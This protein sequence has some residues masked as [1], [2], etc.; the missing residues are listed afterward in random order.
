MPLEMEYADDV[1]F[2]DEEKDT[3]DRLLPVAAQNLK[4]SNLFMNE[5]KTEF[6]HV[7]LSDTQEKE[8]N[9]KPLQGKE[10]WRKSKILGSLLCSSS[11][12]E[13]CCVMGN[14]AF[15][16]FWKIWICGSKIP[17][18]KKLQLYNATCVSIMLYNCN[19][20]AAPK[21]AMDK[22]D[23]CHRKHLRTITGH[24]W[25]DS[26]ISNEALYKMCKTTPLSTKVHQLRWT[27]FGHV[28]RMPEDTPA[29]KALEFAVVGS[30]KYKAH[31]G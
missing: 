4:D 30:N 19:S 16:S 24:K 10:D 20:W 7:Y 27:M 15:Q 5:A 8:E 28:L 6:T 29:Q 26:L 21:A 1:D 31:K 14:I 17:L 18:T 13:A 12:I 2:I 11:D 23:A 3:L 25:P 22:L 9:D